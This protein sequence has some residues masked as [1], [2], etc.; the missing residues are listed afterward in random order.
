MNRF[1][2]PDASATSQLL[3]DLVDALDARGFAITVL[4]GRHGYLNTGAVLPA[5][6]WRAG[7]EVRRLRHTGRGRFSL[8]GRMLDCATFGRARS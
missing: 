5:R 6:A 3:T 1:F 7:I 4:A 8:P 2:H